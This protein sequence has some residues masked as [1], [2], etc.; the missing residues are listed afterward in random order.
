L[1]AERTEPAANSTDTSG[2][3]L[4]VAYKFTAASLGFAPKFGRF[5]VSLGL[6]QVNSFGTAG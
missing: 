6:N 5:D 1:T 3:D 2:V 4:N